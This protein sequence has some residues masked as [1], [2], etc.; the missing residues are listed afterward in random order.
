MKIEL[1]LASLFFGIVVSLPAGTPPPST[2]FKA[3]MRKELDAWETLDYANAAPFYA[4]DADNVFFDLSPLKYTGWKEYAEGVKKENPDLASVK[5]TM[6]PDVRTHQQGNLAWATA[7]LHFELVSKD[8]ATKSLDGRWTLVWEKRGGAW[9]VVHEHV[10]APLPSPA[11]QAAQSLYKRLGGYDALAAVADDFIPRMVKDPQL[12]KYFAG[13]S[14]DSMK[15]IRQMIVD[16]LCQATGG[17]CIYLGRS[18]KAA[19][20]GMGISDSDWDIA[21]DHL[22]ETMIQL[23]V[24][25]KERD[26]VIGVIGTLKSDIVASGG[27]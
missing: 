3:L 17:P 12:G 5:F 13:H 10:S 24:P 7:T 25:G 21:V 15:H 4:K 1:E 8:E 16:Q 19:H 6:G 22:I 14:T 9:L 26:D 11:D 23:K 20:A 2:D 18:M 27:E